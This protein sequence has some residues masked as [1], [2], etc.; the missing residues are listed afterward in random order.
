[1][2]TGIDNDNGS[3]GFHLPRT[4][5]PALLHHHLA[6]SAVAAPHWLHAIFYLLPPPHLPLVQLDVGVGQKAWNILH[7][8]TPYLQHC[9]HA[10]ARTERAKNVGAAHPHAAYHLF[11]AHALPGNVSRCGPFTS[12]CCPVYTMQL[13]GGASPPAATSAHRLLTHARHHMTVAVLTPPHAV[14]PRL[15]PLPS[16]NSISTHARAAFAATAED[17]KGG[18]LRGRG[19][20][21]GT[22]GTV[23]LPPR[24]YCAA[25][26]CPTHH[27]T[28]PSTRVLRS[29]PLGCRCRAP[30]FFTTASPS[31]SA[32]YLRTG[33]S[34]TQF[35]V[36][37]ALPLLRATRRA[38]DCIARSLHLPQR[39]PFSSGGGLRVTALR[40]PAHNA[41]HPTGSG[42]PFGTY[43]AFFYTP[44]PSAHRLPHRTHS[45]PLPLILP[46][47]RAATRSARRG[48]R[49]SL[50][51]ACLSALT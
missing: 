43:N 16:T 22:G 49:F 4:L 14:P 41:S 48:L 47:P 19:R 23:T 28:L 39:A 20:R 21:V 8:V 42:L 32:A 37:A 45:P 12:F 26:R 5:P 33:P 6:F 27:R 31:D 17:R 35:V 24:T 3:E 11:P 40:Y 9:L 51:H 36:F 15:P 46:V 1:M 2:G 44:A 50:P 29:I 10:H 30:P 7:L 25:L 13:V 18:P 34:L 38:P